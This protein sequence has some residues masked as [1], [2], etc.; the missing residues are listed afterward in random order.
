MTAAQRSPMPRRNVTTGSFRRSAWLRI[1]PSGSPKAAGGTPTPVR[2]S[3]DSRYTLRRVE[4][5]PIPVKSLNSQVPPNFTEW[6]SFLPRGV[7]R[8]RVAVNVAALRRV[9]VVAEREV[10]RVQVE[11]LR[12][13]GPDAIAVD[14]AVAQG[15]RVPVPPVHVGEAEIVHQR[16]A[17]D[18]GEADQ[19]LVDVVLV[20]HEVG[21]RHGNAERAAVG[22]AV[23]RVAPEQRVLVAEPDS[24]RVRS[25]GCRRKAPAPACRTGDRRQVRLHD[26][27]ARPDW[28]VRSCRRNESGPS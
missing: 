2:N 12:T 1:F 23:V 4:E 17:Q 7:V 18:A 16:R 27:H 24:P 11:D 15:R 19:L 5:S 10:D 20:R 3:G 22:V 21:R 9:E 26:V 28:C 25:P 8:D 6:A 13:A 14:V